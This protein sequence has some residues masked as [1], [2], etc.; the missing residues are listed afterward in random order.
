[1]NK[2]DAREHGGV[3]LIASGIVQENSHDNNHRN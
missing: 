1:M 2:W 3:S